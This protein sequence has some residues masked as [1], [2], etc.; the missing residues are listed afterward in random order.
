MAY[1]G[2]RRRV[3]PLSIDRVRLPIGAVEAMD[4]T[5]A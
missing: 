4:P 2:G 1:D 5:A 3:S